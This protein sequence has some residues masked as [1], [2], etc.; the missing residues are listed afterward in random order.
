MKR[1]SC[2]AL[3][4][5]LWLCV[6]IAQAAQPRAWLDRNETVL[7]DA[8][9]LNIEAE[10]GDEPDF[11]VLAQDFR[12]V[13]RSSN[14][15]FSIVNGRQTRSTLWAL[16]L[17]PLRTGSIA[18]PAFQ[19]GQEKTDPIT[20][21]VRPAPTAATARAGDDVFLEVEMEPA[22]AYVQQQVRYTI[23]LYYAVSLLEG[24][25]DEPALN[26][27]VL[28]R[29]GQD[30]QATRILENRRY[31]MV[32]RRYLITPQQSGTVTIPGPRFK[33]RV[34]RQGAYGSIFDPGSSVTVRGDE[35]VLSVLPAPTNAPSPWLP[36][37]IVNFKDDAA[38]LPDTLRV[39][40]PV[41][42]SAE[43]SA[44]GV[45]AEQLPE[46][47]LPGIA[48]A[49]V[50]PDQEA[51]QTVD[52]QN[53]T[54]AI[55][56]RKFAIVPTQVGTLELPERTVSWWNVNTG[57][58]ENIVLPARSFTVLA[59]EGSASTSS[60]SGASFPSG[61]GSDVTDTRTLR[62]W[63]FAAAGFALLWIATLI[64]W[65]RAPRATASPTDGRDAAQDPPRAWR[66]QFQHA[67]AHRD[68]SAARSALLRSA[69]GVSGLSELAEKLADAKQREAAIALE[70]ALYR[71][72]SRDGLVERLREAFANGVTLVEKNVAQRE[73]SL[74]PL[75]R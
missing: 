69:P 75:Y 47:S 53:A 51:S 24:Q 58:A 35:L 8:V 60:P 50:Y 27:A 1:H 54:R 41:T 64:A 18:I 22:S 28:R 74:P 3:F 43:L 48:N 2:I 49:Q 9:T 19:I 73:E 42:L 16:A 23:R 37:T 13:S 40:E 38:R 21:V 36:A 70:R 5:W 46:L 12:I 34:A 20:L 25:I 55:R 62:L 71:G 10:T 72:E 33:G 4:V 63:Q 66:T 57:K 26:K 15:T 11:S 45:T 31:S 59:A 30:T 61:D 6:G 65:R 14:A 17:E 44:D 7:G 52:L 68:L 32:E 67:L 56:S 39:G 29:L